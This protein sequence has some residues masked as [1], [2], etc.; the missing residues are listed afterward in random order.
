MVFFASVILVAVLAASAVALE[1]KV[2][3]SGGNETS[4]HQYGFLHEVRAFIG[5]ETKARRLMRSL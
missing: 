4:G 3:A 2:A 1:I 5:S